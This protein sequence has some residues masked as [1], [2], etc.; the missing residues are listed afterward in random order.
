MEESAFVRA[1][2][3]APDFH[4][5]QGDCPMAAMRKPEGVSICAPGSI[6]RQS[7][8]VLGRGCGRPL[9]CQ[10]LDSQ[11]PT[12]SGRGTHGFATRWSG[13]AEFE[14]A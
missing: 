1:F 9:P 5:L 13:V 3:I 2:F 7:A 14:R 6:W 4:L 10:G 11:V 8:E 12:V